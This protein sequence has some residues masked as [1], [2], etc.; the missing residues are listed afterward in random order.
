MSRT[1]QTII[2]QS[3]AW[4]RVHRWE[5]AWMPQAATGI[6]EA[7]D[8]VG[9]TQTL[10]ATVDEPPVHC[11]RDTSTGGVALRKDIR[12]PSG[13]HSWA[14]TPTRVDEGERLAPGCFRVRE[15]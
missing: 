7:R 14:I 8:N 15:L 4:G 9:T 5:V 6:D 13:T 2:E 10:W 3:D 11:V 1:L 12:R